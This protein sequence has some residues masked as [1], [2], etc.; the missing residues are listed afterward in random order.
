M[1]ATPPYNRERAINDIYHQGRG[2]SLAILRADFGGVWPPRGLVI[3]QP[4]AHEITLQRYTKIFSGE[5]ASVSNQE[6]DH[7]IH[8]NRWGH[9]SSLFNRDSQAR[10]DTIAH[11]NIHILQ[12]IMIQQGLRNS[13]GQFYRHGVKEMVHKNAGSYARYLCAEDEFQVRLHLLV[14]RY[15]RDHGKIPLNQH[16]LWSMLHHEGV[17]ITDNCLQALY[18]SDQGLRALGKFF[19]DPKTLP[20]FKSGLMREIN[21]ALY[22]ISDHHKEKFCRVTIPALY[23]S[24]LEIY[25]DREG[26]RRM[27]YGHNISLTEMFLHQ[28]GR[29]Q[30][31][32]EN[33]LMPDTSRIKTIIAA[34]PDD[35]KQD[36][37]CSLQQGTFIHPLTGRTRKIGQESATLIAPLLP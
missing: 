9:L 17:K 7:C 23:G 19:R 14:S 10:A 3:T 36:I 20:L 4:P 25:G 12:K 21:T 26:S 6:H 13:F 5:T 29:L 16:E 8:I 1:A 37:A 34:M 15:Y 11:E 28:A 18:E 2:D 30:Y 33:K 24:L 32:M 35:Q 27:G 22:S 31:R